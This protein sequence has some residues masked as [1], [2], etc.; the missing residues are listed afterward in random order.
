MKDYYFLTL[1]SLRCQPHWQNTQSKRNNQ[2]LPK[3]LPAL[4]AQTLG[5]HDSTVNLDI[6][7]IN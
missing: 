6:K 7:M 3:N 1:P 5:G 2:I 4:H